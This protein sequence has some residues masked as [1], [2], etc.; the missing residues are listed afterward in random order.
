MSYYAGGNSNFDEKTGQY[1]TGTKPFDS[2]AYNA[3]AD[4]HYKAGTQMDPNEYA[5]YGGNVADYGKLYG[6]TAWYTQDGGYTTKSPYYTDATK[7]HEQAGTQMDPWEAAKYGIS[8]AQYGNLYGNTSWYN[9]D[10][11]RTANAPTWLQ[12]ATNPQVTKT[13][14][15]KYVDPSYVSTKVNFNPNYQ[16]LNTQVGD[17]PQVNFQAMDKVPGYQDYLPQSIES[18]P[19]YQYQLKQGLGDLDKYMAAKGLNISGANAEAAQ[20][21]VSQLTAE[22]SERMAQRASDQANRAER[23]GIANLNTKGLYD[24]TNANNSLSSLLTQAKISS[25]EAAKMNDY[26]YNTALQKAL[27]DQQ[28]KQGRRDF[29]WN[30]AIAKNSYNAGNADKLINMQQFGANRADA[31]QQNKWNNFFDT[32]GLLTAQNPMGMAS[33]GTENLANLLMQ[34]AAARGSGGGGG[35]S[36]GAAIPPMLPPSGPNYSNLAPFMAGAD[37]SQN[38]GSANILANVFGSLFQ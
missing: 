1:K 19:L 20:R 18:S 5:S 36:S 31:L 10:G 17:A 12:P 37:Y 15:P 29:E 4:K 8:Q 2:N 9:P 14:F 38:T 21:L 11:S 6:D 7:K 30:N 24:T 35:G 33:A 3:A 13:M 34:A 26:R 22:E 16:K 28:A 25:D 32:L 23:I 27:F